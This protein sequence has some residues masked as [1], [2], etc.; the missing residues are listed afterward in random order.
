MKNAAI[1]AALPLLFLVPGDS[2]PRVPVRVGGARPAIAR[3]GP[4]HTPS[5]SNVARPNIVRP[6]GVH[7]G[8]VPQQ[9]PNINIANRPNFVNRPNVGVVNRPNVVTNRPN[10]VNRPI[11]FNQQITSVNKTRVNNINRTNLYAGGRAAWGGRP[12]Y[13]YYGNYNSRWVRGHWNRW[14]W[15][16][17][18]WGA[19]AATLGWLGTGGNT[20]VY[21]NPFYVVPQT[22]VIQVPAVDYSQPIVAPPAP[23]APSSPSVIYPIAA[24]AAAEQPSEPAAE[25]EVPAEVT[26]L[27]DAARA[28]FR[29]GD[30]ARALTQI[31]QAIDKLPD[32]A[33]L[34]ELRAL[35]QFAL[36]DY[37]G[38]AATI[39]AVLDAGPGWDWATVQGLYADPATYTAQLRALETYQKAN[40]D[41]ADASFLL[42]Y[43]YLVLNH[44]EAAA[45]QLE[46]VI[47]L[48]PKDQL[49]PRLLQAIRPGSQD[50]P[51]PQP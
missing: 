9:Q 21:S 48:V 43:H 4:V 38:A 18:A 13:N 39:Y 49:A 46:N 15:N 28:A 3:P 35:V 32:D 14:N 24:A 20:Y 51:A 34:H 31:D 12:Y 47:R 27:A 41:A 2:Y 16:P 11:N 5:F 50:R 33:A 7:P 44:P 6:G 17:W 23:P 25:P 10:I 42:A 45:K 37:A 29:A 1:L 36:K 26:R 8:F 30:Y 19:G 40:P 22:T